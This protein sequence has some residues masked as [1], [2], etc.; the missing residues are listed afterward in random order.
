MK[1][2]A[3]DLQDVLFLSV[4]VSH[5]SGYFSVHFLKLLYLFWG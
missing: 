3:T 1:G 5:S 4:A 2:P